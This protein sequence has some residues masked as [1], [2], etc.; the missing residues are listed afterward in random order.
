[1]VGEWLGG[2]MVE[3]IDGWMDGWTDAVLT[4]EFF[5][6]ILHVRKVAKKIP[7]F[8]K[9]S[10]SSHSYVRRE[11]RTDEWM[12]GQTENTD[13]LTDGRTTDRQTDR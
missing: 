8:S 11:R 12:D 6:D 1:M 13:V 9:Y 10:T 7:S 5:L 4:L 2:R 3:Q